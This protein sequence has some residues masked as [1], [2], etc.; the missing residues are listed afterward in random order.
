MLLLDNL[1]RDLGLC[2]RTVVIDINA[3]AYL[4]NEIK[5]DR[6]GYRSYFHDMPIISHPPT[7]SCGAYFDLIYICG[8]EL[9]MGGGYTI[10]DSCAKHQKSSSGG[11]F[12]EAAGEWIKDICKA[13]SGGDD[14]GGDGGDGGGDDDSA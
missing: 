9:L 11:K 1:W 10:C 14:N 8:N 7:K 5:G 3:C 6:P 2:S 12:G 4:K 13:V